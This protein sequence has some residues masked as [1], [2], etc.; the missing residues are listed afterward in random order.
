MVRDLAWIG[1]AF[2]LCPL[3]ALL[4]TDDPAGPV[5]AAHGILSVEA[6]LGIDVEAGWA[7][8]LAQHPA[9]GAVLAAI[10]LFAHVPATVGALTWL[11]IDRPAA[12]PKARDALLATQALTIATYLL[13]PVAP[14][15]LATGAP[16]AVSALMGGGTGALSGVLQSPLA[17]MPSGHVAFATIVGLVLWDQRG[18]FRAVLA[19]AYPLLVA[20]IVVVTGNHFVLDVLGG[21]LAASLGWAGATVRMRGAEAGRTAQPRRRPLAPPRSTA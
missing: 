12:Y 7:A 16:D 8:W 17:A 2:A 5:R 11:R 20:W 21:V 4:A 9:L 3:A 1:L 14:P 13:W 15:R 10:Y 18:R 19:V 6:E